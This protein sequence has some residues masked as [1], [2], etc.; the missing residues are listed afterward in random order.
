MMSLGSILSIHFDRLG[1][2]HSWY[3]KNGKIKWLDSLKT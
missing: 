2:V 1:A 3:N